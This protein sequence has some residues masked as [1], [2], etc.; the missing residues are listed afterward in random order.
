MKCPVA[1]VTSCFDVPA[2]SLSLLMREVPR[3]SNGSTRFSRNPA[4][5]SHV[6]VTDLA[7]DFSSPCPGF[8][9]AVLAVLRCWPIC[10][11]RHHHGARPRSALPG[12]AFVAKAAGQ[13]RAS[14]S[15]LVSPSADLGM[16]NSISEQRTIPNSGAMLNSQSARDWQ[17]QPARRRSA[18]YAC[19]R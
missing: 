15:L 18:K 19:S 6:R 13:Q 14:C 16:I 17:I 8:V 10:F 4:I 5:A 12:G 1:S 7:H 11:H 3:I 9:K 2:D